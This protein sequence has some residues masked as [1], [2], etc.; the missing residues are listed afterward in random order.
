M[1]LALQPHSE[2]TESVREAP[3]PAT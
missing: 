2:K 3:R 1:L